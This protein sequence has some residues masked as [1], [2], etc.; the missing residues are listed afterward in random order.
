MMLFIDK[1]VAR[2]PKVLCVLIGGACVLSSF[3]LGHIRR[4]NYML[5][6]LLVNIKKLLKVD[7]RGRVEVITT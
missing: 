1:I 3:F 6:V 7:T 2:T 5:R 4:R